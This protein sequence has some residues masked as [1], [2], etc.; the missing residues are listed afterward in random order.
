M[1]SLMELPQEIRAMIFE[2]AL[3]AHRTPPVRP[4]TLNMVFLLD[5]R[6]KAYL[7]YLVPFH[8]RRD[9]HSPSNDLPLLLT[10]RQVFEETKSTL[11]RMERTTYFLD[12]SVLDDQYLF[13]SWISVPKLTTCLSTL[14]VDVRLFGRILTAEEGRRQLGSGGRWGFHWCFYAL[15]ERFLQYGPVGEKK[16]CWDDKGRLYYESRRISVENLILDFQSAE[17]E[18]PFPPD[19]VEFEAWH[20]KHQG[21]TVDGQIEHSLEYKT[22][23]EWLLLD[24]TDWLEII[25]RISTGT[26]KW[27]K[28]I[29]E[30]IGSIFMLVDGRLHTTIDLAGE[31]AKYKCDKPPHFMANVELSTLR[32]RDW[33][34]K[35]ATLLR[36]EELGFP[37]VWPGDG[38]I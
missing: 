29:Y 11:N 30:R 5:M 23:P 32:A 17:T 6:Y 34:W 26:K 4:S 12:I 19:D 10:S 16:P 15:L 25:I 36:R 21:Y 28:I 38:E 27:G 9:S 8:E 18:L 20:A 14:H 1:P 37:V 22:R 7:R 3:N 35:I 2:E 33:E 31:L 13:S 24:L